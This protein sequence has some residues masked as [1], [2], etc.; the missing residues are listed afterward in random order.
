[1]FAGLP[2]NR[3]KAHGKKFCNAYGIATEDA[4]TAIN[5]WQKAAERNDGMGNTDERQ[6][7]RK[8]LVL[9]AIDVRKAGQGRTCVLEGRGER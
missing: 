5:D 1:M 6:G 9:I 4:G 7:R 2:T 3:T 8:S